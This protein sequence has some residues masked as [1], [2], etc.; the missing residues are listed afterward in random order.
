M[1]QIL[2]TG[3]NSYIGSSFI[4][5]I[6]KSSDCKDYNIV[7][8]DV[9]NNEWIKFDFS[10]FDTVIH[11]AGIVHR[12]VKDQSLY[13]NV[14]S[15]LTLEIAKKSKSSGV[16]HFIFMSTISVYGKLNGT[17]SID[18]EFNPKNNYAKSKLKGEI[19]LKQLES[20]SFK[21][22]IVR[23]PLVYGINCKGNYVRLVNLSKY[24]ILLPKYTNQRDMIYIDNLSLFIK[25]I[26]DKKINGIILPSDGFSWSTNEIFT[27]YRDIMGK[28][29][30]YLP[31]SAIAVK[32]LIKFIKNVKKVYGDF[33]LSSEINN[34]NSSIFNDGSDLRMN[35]E[36]I[37]HVLKEKTL[38]ENFIS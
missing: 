35:K 3:L 32:I 24:S 12:K 8:L 27:F 7:Q 25:K 20:D 36:M 28:R 16:T 15:Y 38:N 17:I 23:P 11:V 34:K 14:N 30:L 19:L 1:K 10:G 6:N 4:N 37:K 13:Y 2:I 29:T 26:I 21:L 18:T 31:L 9:S 5:F 22:S 33:V